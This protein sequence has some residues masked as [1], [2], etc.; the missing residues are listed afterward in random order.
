[1]GYKRVLCAY[2]PHTY[3][4]TE[5]LFEDF[6]SS[7][8]LADRVYFADI[9]AAREQNESGISSKQLADRLGEKALYCG[10]FQTLADALIRESGEGDLLLIMGAGDI[11]CME[12]LLP[13]KK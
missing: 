13:L 9:Y 1:M 6:V 10:D 2:Q 3:S 11:D 5:G 4:R 7:F 8:A 12:G